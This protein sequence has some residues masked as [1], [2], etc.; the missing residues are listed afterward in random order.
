MGD[1]PATVSP[2]MIRRL[3]PAVA[4]LAITL[5]AGEPDRVVTAIVVRVIAAV[6]GPAATRARVSTGVSRSAR[7]RAARSGRGAW[8]A[9]RRSR[10]SVGSGV[11]AGK[12]ERSS[13]RMRAGQAGRRPV[14]G[15]RGGVA[16]PPLDRELQR[17]DA[18]LG[19]PDDADRR[20]HAG[21]GVVRDRAALVDDEPGSDAA[22]A[23][24]GDR[25]RR[26]VAEDLLVAAEGEP[27][28]LRGGEPVVEELLD[29]LADRHQ[30]PLVVE[31]AAPPD[32]AVVDLGA[33]GRVLPGCLILDGDDVEVGHQH[34]RAVVARSCPAEQQAVGVDPGQLEVVVQQGVA[35]LE[36]VDERVE[37]PGVDE[38][39]VAVGDGGDPDQGP[40]PLDRVVTAVRHGAE[41]TAPSGRG[42]P[43]RPRAP[44]SG[45]TA[46][47]GRRCRR[48]GGRS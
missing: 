21:E 36:L 42:A 44:A 19:D 11:L 35:A 5:S 2:S 45:G 12:G 9:I 25:Q 16:T 39:G 29:G 48:R 28:V 15:R 22:L 1:R 13:R 33:E 18:L 40:Q 6:S 41:T 37:R 38:G 23:E 4:L 46:S 10:A 32:G 34:D 17:G 7:R 20:G 14:A 43:T 3:T 24:L 8:G 30:G 31:R 47:P 27:E 26:R